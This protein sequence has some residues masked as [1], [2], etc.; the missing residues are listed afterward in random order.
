[1]KNET[2]HFTKLTEP[3]AEITAVFNTTPSKV[4]GSACNDYNANYTV[5]GNTLTINPPAATSKAAP[6]R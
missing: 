1:M 6:T 2:I 4:A 5:N 3:T